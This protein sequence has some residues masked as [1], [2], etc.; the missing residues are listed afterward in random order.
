MAFQ[1]EEIVQPRDGG[2]KLVHEV[3]KELFMA[4]KITPFL[5]FKNE[6]EEATRFYVSLFNDAEILKIDRIDGDG[7]VFTTAFRLEDQEYIALN[8]GPEDGD[9]SKFNDSISFL[10]RCDDQDEVDHFWDTLTAGGKP[11][12]CGWLKDKFGVT[13]QVT[14]RALDELLAGPDREGADRAVKALSEMTKIDVAELKAAYD[15][16]LVN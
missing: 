11:I 2:T 12:G 8:G 7:P 10:I 15:G 6:A 1:F 16:A 5:W 13:W 4:R 14:P 9:Q 3:K